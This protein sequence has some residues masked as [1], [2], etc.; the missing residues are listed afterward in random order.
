MIDHIRFV[1]KAYEAYVHGPITSADMGHPDAFYSLP[2]ES[3]VN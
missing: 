3:M 2:E 1:N